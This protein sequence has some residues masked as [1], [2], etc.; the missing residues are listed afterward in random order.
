MS[1][2]SELLRAHRQ[3]Q[4][5]SQA[6]LGRRAGICHS[7]ISRLEK[8]E[9]RPS[10]KVVNK[11]ARALQLTIP[12]TSSLLASV[13]VRKEEFGHPLLVEIQAL[14]NNEAIPEVF[15]EA[16]MKRLETTFH[17]YKRSAA[18]YESYAS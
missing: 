13:E 6:E 17:G 14:L 16:M 11:I 2:F 4:G 18:M 9:R 7:S 10:T 5:I 8:G 15:K 3:E 1:S 12:E